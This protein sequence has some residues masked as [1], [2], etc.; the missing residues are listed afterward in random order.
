MKE[1]ERSV[2]E[3]HYLLFLRLLTALRTAAAH[4]HVG[5]VNFEDSF[6][7]IWRRV[8][9][10]VLVDRLQF[11]FLVFLLVGRAFERS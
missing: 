6:D 10:Y 9:P 3:D 1:V 2:V 7:Q 11:F 5:L 4:K 8:L